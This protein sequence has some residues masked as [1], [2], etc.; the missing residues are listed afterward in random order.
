MTDLRRGRTDP[1]QLARRRAESQPEPQ[2]G[3]EQLSLVE[4]DAPLLAISAPEARAVKYVEDAR[5]A[6]AATAGS[7]CANCGLYQG[8]SGSAQGPCQLFTGKQVKAA[9]WC[10]AWAPQM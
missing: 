3:C 1:D 8:P 6:S 10:T 9:G 5:Q 7:N 2:L 4:A